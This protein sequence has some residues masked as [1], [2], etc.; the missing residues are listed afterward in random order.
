MNKCMENKV[1]TQETMQ[2]KKKHNKRRKEMN[3]RNL[4]KLEKNNFKV[5]V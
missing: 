1:K 5:N 3:V 2:S 4:N